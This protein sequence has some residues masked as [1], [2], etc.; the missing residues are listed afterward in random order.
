MPKYLLT[1]GQKK[2]PLTAFKPEVRNG[3][4][5]KRQ[6]E[7]V[8]TPNKVVDT[9]EYTL[10]HWLKTGI[11]VKVSEGPQKS[12]L[13][14]PVAPAPVVPSTVHTK[15]MT[16]DEG[17]VSISTMPKPK[18]DDDDDDELIG[19]PEDDDSVPPIA[20]VP[21]PAPA[22][23]TPVFEDD[24]EDEEDEVLADYEETDDGSFRCL[25]CAKDGVDKVL[26]TEAGMIKHIQDK[27]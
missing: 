13:P 18:V 24:D 12:T 25:I 5:V 20:P 15:E 1:R 6:Q 9:G 4:E 19:V 22:P 17:V 2:K 8:L 23:A 14:T 27:H 3:K 7:F 26:K 11:V 16:K 10:D 21:T